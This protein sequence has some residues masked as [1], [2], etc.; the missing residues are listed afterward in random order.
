MKRNPLS[1]YL[2]LLASAPGAA[3]A[4]P[5]NESCSVATDLGNLPL[6]NTVSGN[7]ESTAAFGDVDYYRLSAT[8]G[9]RLA[10]NIQGTRTSTQVGGTLVGVF[11]SSCT[12]QQMTRF[13]RLVLT[14]PADGV[15]I[16]AASQEPD[17]S[18]AG[19]SGVGPYGIE[20]RAYQEIGTIS[21]TLLD[22]DSGA[23]ISY[24][25]WPQLELDRCTDASCAQTQAVAYTYADWWSGDFRFSTDW[26]GLPLESGTYR[27]VATAAGYLPGSVI[28]TAQVGDSPALGVLTIAQQPGIGSISGAFVDRDG[29]APLSGSIYL[30]QCL[31]EDCSSSTMVMNAYVYDGGRFSFTT[32]FAGQRLPA[33]VY[34]LSFTASWPYRH[35]PYVSA[36]FSVGVDEDL[37]V[38]DLAVFPYPTITAIRG[39]V[40]D[41]LTH[42]GLSGVSEPYAQITVRNC[43]P[44]GGICWWTQVRPDS[45]GN[46]R[47]D[48]D[49][50]G[51]PLFAG[52]TQISVTASQYQ[53]TTIEVNDL[54]AGQE[55]DVG[56]LGVASNPVRFINSRPC[57]S[58][59]ARGGRCRFSVTMVNGQAAALNATVW[60]EISASGIGSY[61][62]YSNFTAGKQ[63]TRFPAGTRG[64]SRTVS[65]E[66]DV[67]GTVANYAS[68][69]AT[70]YVG[71]DGPSSFLDTVGASFL[72]CMMKD[73]N[74][75]SYRQVSEHES[76]ALLQKPLDALRP[77]H[78]APLQQLR[79]RSR[80]SR[81]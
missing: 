48:A 57:A 78:E 53:W 2:F 49:L 65:F 73:P 6:P 79:A 12:L 66:L 76:R 43:A 51:Y 45:S 11:D 44:L 64:Q 34:T 23:P 30:N 54:V 80:P 15:L 60:S 18:F 52:P 24:Y 70:V 10:L 13:D 32:N 36:P 71:Q 74:A 5:G 77:S 61:L 9:S 39:R 46:F 7:L 67:P 25:S 3:L 17:Y 31:N 42:A 41:V 63:S 28:F 14:V 22:A 40:Q 68:F 58:V 38:G 1:L 72:Y 27:I 55:K 81:R 33:A 37:E 4:A 16:L 21:G 69:C 59:P 29:G 56:T 26:Y 47:L 8:P 20:L 35:Q 50:N 75:P 19:G 62:G